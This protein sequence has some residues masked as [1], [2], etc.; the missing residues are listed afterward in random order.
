MR[1]GPDSMLFAATVASARR[2]N[3]RHFKSLG[4]EFN[5]SVSAMAIRLR[6]LGL[7]EE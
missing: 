7:I 2:F 1:A 3:G 5:I 6:E 4:E